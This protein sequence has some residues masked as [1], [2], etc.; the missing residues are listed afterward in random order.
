MRLTSLLVASFAL[1]AA[2]GAD[3]A[4][5]TMPASAEIALRE[6]REHFTYEGKPIHPGMVR[7]FSGWLSDGGP[8]TLS[9]D[10]R[11]GSGTDQ[12][13]DRDV[14]QIAKQVIVHEEGHEAAWFGYERIGVLNDGTQVLRTEECGGGSGIFL[15]IMFVRFRIQLHAD[16]RVASDFRLVMEVVSDHPIGDR[17][18]G[19]VVIAGDHVVAGK[20][21]YRKNDVVLR[22]MP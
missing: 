19:K 11:A 3:A 22:P 12:Y 2:S 18:D 7:Q 4:P 6:A 16:A 8:I 10:V 14:N 9:V 21:R 17:D 13:S 5:T 20:S 1:L 15:S